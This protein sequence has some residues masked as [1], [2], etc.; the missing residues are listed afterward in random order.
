MTR[1]CCKRVDLVVMFHALHKVMVPFDPT[2]L[3]IQSLYFHGLVTKLEKR[4][5]HLWNS[6]G[7]LKH[8]K[9]IARLM[10]LLFHHYVLF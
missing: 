8:E 5:T 3:S 2:W 6:L 1:D 7:I 4:L 9:V 10:N